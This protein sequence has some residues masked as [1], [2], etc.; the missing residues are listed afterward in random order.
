MLLD[1]TDVFCFLL[2]FGAKLFPVGAESS[3]FLLTFAM[4]A[5]NSDLIHQAM[6]I[7]VSPPFTDL[8]VRS[9]S[10]LSG[11]AKPLISLGHPG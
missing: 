2:L 5:L 11:P 8:C 4:W 1:A 7:F 3:R 9:Q 10:L 6:I